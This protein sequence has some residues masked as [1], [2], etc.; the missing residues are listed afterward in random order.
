VDGASPSEAEGVRTGLLT[1]ASHSPGRL[2]Y[3]FLSGGVGG[4]HKPPHPPLLARA[5]CRS[6]ANSFFP[7]P[8][9]A[10]CGASENINPRANAPC[11][12]LPLGGNLQGWDRISRDA[13]QSVIALAASAGDK[14]EPTPVNN[15][16]SDNRERYPGRG[17]N[18]YA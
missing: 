14:L 3:R 15:V 11:L 5:Q 10:R 7:I 16:G 17:A 18:G 12:S 4:H 2:L 13:G 1:Q 6:S 8:M 9:L